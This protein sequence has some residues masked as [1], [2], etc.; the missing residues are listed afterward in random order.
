MSM[1]FAPT[2]GA[3]SAPL[4]SPRKRGDDDSLSAGE[5]GGLAEAIGAA[6]AASEHGKVKPRL[7]NLS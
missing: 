4:W 5:Q 1:T 3:V 7:G 2:M 6:A